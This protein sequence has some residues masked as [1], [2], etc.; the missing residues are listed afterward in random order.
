MRGVGVNPQQ[1]DSEIIET[2]K[3]SVPDHITEKI[4]R[5]KARLLVEHPYFGTLAGRLDFSL[6]D[7]IK[8][9]ISD[10]VR[11]EF[12]DDYLESLDL[13]ELG[14]ALANG[15]MHAALLHESRKK[16]RLKW[17]WQLATD[18]A[19]N[20][21]LVQNGL[22][23][24]PHI[25]YEARFEGMYAEAIYEILKD[26]I[27]NEEYDDNEANDTGYNEEEKRHQEQMKNAEGDHDKDKKRPKME[28]ENVEQKV[29][30]PELTEEEKFEQLARDAMEK[31]SKSGDLPEGIERF[32]TL[33][34]RGKID[35]RQELY[36]AIEEHYKSDYRMMPPSKKLLYMGTY[37]PS[38]G[39]DMLRIVIAIDS[40][41]SVDEVL[42]GTFIAEVESLMLSFSNY[43]IDLLVCDARVHSHETFYGGDR[44]EYTLKGG[45]G[46]DF[47]PVFAYIDEQLYDTR[48]LL[49][50][51]DTDGRVPDDE[52]LFETVW[53][54]PVDA[55]MP[56]GRVLVLEE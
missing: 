15:A 46:T 7:N 36:M 6:N 14:F 26:E 29:D 11:F 40:S 35:W 1:I 47:R 54:S 18:Y 31:M 45:G 3:R 48:L 22:S 42:L 44:L 23:E 5:A 17:L 24:P 27:Q 33:D 41:G 12:N 10:G 16:G 19:I 39:S 49:Y 52:P 53:V 56:F 51:T 25:Q 43:Q 30:F 4:S 50:F 55:E 38:L 28:V 2:L 21:M 37:L 9:F 8:S 13:D 34:V 20:A 32:F